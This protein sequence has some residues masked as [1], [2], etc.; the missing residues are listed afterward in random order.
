MS[1]DF[2]DRV[3]LAISG[4]ED[5]L[6]ASLL[7]PR[8]SIGVQSKTMEE[9]A[10]IRP[11][12]VLLSSNA[13][14]DVVSTLEWYAV[15]VLPDKAL[16]NQDLEAF[17]TSDEIFSPAIGPPQVTS[18]KVGSTDWDPAFV[19]WVDPLDHVGYDIQSGNSQQT[20]L[21]WSNI[22]QI[23]VQFSEDVQITASDIQ[24]TGIHP[25]RC[26]SATHATT[27]DTIIAA[28]N[29]R[30]CHPSFLAPPGGVAR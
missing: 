20:P 23:F 2:E 22:N 21:P 3:H 5:G 14:Q 7:L 27:P 18:V 6:G 16:T 28:G 25:S 13:A 30:P 24:L 4:S 19:S 29:E 12:E 15:Q 1:L 10:V 11:Q 26:A 8:N 9:L 17:V